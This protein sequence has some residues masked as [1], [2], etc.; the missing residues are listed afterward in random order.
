MNY[1]YEIPE[2][3]SVLGRPGGGYYMLTDCS[4]AQGGRM[5]HA[6]HDFAFKDAIRVWLE[7]ANGVTLVKAP[8]GNTSWGEVDPKEFTWIK[9]KARKFGE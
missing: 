1:Y 3:I 8:R 9:L 2:N 7:N 6:I 4:P 5:N